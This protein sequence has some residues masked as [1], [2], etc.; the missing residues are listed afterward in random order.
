[1]AEA[2]APYIEVGAA[3]PNHANHQPT[4]GGAGHSGRGTAAGGG[5]GGRG[6]G[7]RGR[8]G[9]A[10]AAGGGGAGEQQNYHLHQPLVDWVWAYFTGQH[11]PSACMAPLA[12][13]GQQQGPGAQQ[14]G[15]GQGSV[16]GGAGGGLAALGL[17]PSAVT[18]TGLPPLYFQVGGGA[19]GGEGEERRAREVGRGGREGERALGDCRDGGAGCLARAAYVAW[20][21]ERAVPVVLLSPLGEAAGQILPGQAGLYTALHAPGS[22]PLPTAHSP[23]HPRA[24][25]APGCVG[26]CLC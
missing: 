6:A 22:A 20:D 14:Q 18:V 16:Q 19:G 1:M 11:A 10:A 23:L 3:P 4:S 13:R 7:G 24:T 2:A 15:Q 12:Q 21:D 9:R 26:N 25:N 17:R 8:G 5:R